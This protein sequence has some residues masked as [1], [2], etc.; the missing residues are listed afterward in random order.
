MCGELCQARLLTREEEYD[1]GTKIQV[2]MGYIEV[3]NRLMS[4][5]GRVPSAEEWAEACCL[6]LGEFEVRRM[7]FHL[8][9]PITGGISF[10]LSFRG[11]ACRPAVEM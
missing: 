7:S 11:V 1:L 4:H 9:F 10:L 2:L 5:L 3:R 6:P 8:F